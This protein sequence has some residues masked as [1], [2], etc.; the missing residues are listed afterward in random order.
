MNSD[1]HD[2]QSPEDVK[3]LVHKFYEQLL[4]DE[5]INHHFK[6]I[7]QLEEHLKVIESFWNTLLLGTM[8]YKNNTVQAHRHLDL[9]KEEFTIWIR[10]FK[11][12]VDI[13]FEGDKAEEAK[14]RAAT[15]GITMRYKLLG[16]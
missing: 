1:K 5:G 7:P 6:D 9:K 12:T 14:S 3:L 11:N 8:E 2:I 4:S 16:E 15:I 10:H 13:Y